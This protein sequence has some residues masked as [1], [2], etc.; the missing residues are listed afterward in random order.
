VNTIE[1]EKHVNSPDS[2]KFEGT[3]AVFFPIDEQWG[4]KLFRCEETR[5][6]SYNRHT[7]LYDMGL[8]PMYGPKNTLVYDGETWYG[9]LCEIVECCDTAVLDHYGVEHD[10]KCQGGDYFELCSYDSYSDFLMENE[11]WGT[12]DVELRGR[13]E[14]EGIR[15][16]DTHAGNWGIRKNGQ[17]VLIDFDKGLYGVD[18]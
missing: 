13:L 1:L 3:T 15:F 17:P 11:K 10:G 6:L 4:V 14:E 18:I 5:D 7:T 8:A 16:T 9:Y 2:S 12:A